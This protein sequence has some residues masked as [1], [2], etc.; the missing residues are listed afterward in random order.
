MDKR[1]KRESFSPPAIG[2]SS[3]LTVFA[4]LALTVFALLSLSTVRADVRLADAA[5][6]AVTGYYAAD[7]KAQEIL[8]RLRNGETP[9]GVE[10][11][12]DKI[13]VMRKEGSPPEY[14]FR[15]E[16]VRVAEYA[17]PISETQELR[18]KVIL[19]GAD[20]EVVC[21]Q[22]APSGEWTGGDNFTV[23]DGN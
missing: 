20:Y 16:V 19:R 1:E 21:W 3:L 17:L 22:A 5:A 12:T 13:D 7:C 6:E 10:S 14:V 4:V 23:W 2:G 15:P 18:V 11:R 8:A 9:E